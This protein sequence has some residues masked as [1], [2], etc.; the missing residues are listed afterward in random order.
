MLNWLEDSPLHPA[1]RK[2]TIE[3]LE[4]FA[5]YFGMT[6]DRVVHFDARM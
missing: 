4:R 5:S 2:I 6:I 3:E 1:S